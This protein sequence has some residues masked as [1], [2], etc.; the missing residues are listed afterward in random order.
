MKGNKMMC[1]NNSL[2]YIKIYGQS[3]GHCIEGHQPTLA[4]KDFCIVFKLTLYYEV[5]RDWGGRH[6]L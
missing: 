2:K 6:T 5:H 1:F 4:N 3:A